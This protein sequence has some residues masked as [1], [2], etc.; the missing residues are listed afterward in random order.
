M[1]TDSLAP[2]E[3]FSG[4]VMQGQVN[5]LHRIL[6]TDGDS[7]THGPN[8]EAPTRIDGRVETAE[9]ADEG[10][11]GWQSLCMLAN[12]GASLLRRVFP[13]ARTRDHSR[14][15]FTILPFI[16]VILF[17]NPNVSA[18]VLSPSIYTDTTSAGTVQNGTGNCCGRPA[19][20]SCTESPLPVSRCLTLQ[21]SSW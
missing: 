17:T 8:A 14:S 10:V 9:N 15:E 20:F 16:C 21:R 5:L 11:T 7:N 3:K 2:N 12:A 18:G 6:L 4:G 1:K 13:F 19:G